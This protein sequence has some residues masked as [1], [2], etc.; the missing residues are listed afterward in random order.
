MLETFP[1]LAASCGHD[2][3]GMDDEQYAEAIAFVRMRD[4]ERMREQTLAA[5]K[6]RV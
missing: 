5:V 3:L 6:G 2:L 4:D 1:H